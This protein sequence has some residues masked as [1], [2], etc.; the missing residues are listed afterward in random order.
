MAAP[1]VLLG[2]V[3]G[4]AGLALLRRGR[5]LVAQGL[6]WATKAGVRL[7]AGAEALLDRLAAAAGVPITVTSGTRSPAEQAQAM[8]SK[9][10]RGEDLTAL[11]GQD[12]LVAEVLAAAKSPSA[13]DV[14]A[15]AAVIE[16]QVRRGRFISRHLR[17]DALDL[18]TRDLS[19]DQ[20]AALKAA[21]SQLG[22]RWLDEGDHIH[23]DHL[24]L[25]R[26]PA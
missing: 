22:L 10:Q 3:A 20:L 25:T 6:C 2:L 5:D 11:Y 12:D 14:E 7:P 4:L 13:P 9:L 23:V 15:M 1:V 21:L 26:S 24:P 16:D 19:A 8:A 17:G 18:R